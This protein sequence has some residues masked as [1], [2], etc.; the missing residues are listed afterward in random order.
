M[1]RR[2]GLF[3]LFTAALLLLSLLSGARL[4]Y[5]LFFVFTAYLGAAQ[6]ILRANSRD[7][8]HF[9]DF[10]EAELEVGEV[11]SLDFKFENL[12]WL[13]IMG[14]RV[15][16]E[17]LEGLYHVDFHTERH[18]LGSY[19]RVNTRKELTMDHRGYFTVGRILVHFVDPLGCFEK[20]RRF[21]KGIAL[22][23]YPKTRRLITEGWL[24]TYPSEAGSEGKHT[25]QEGDPGGIRPYVLGE[26]LKR[27]L[28][29]H[30]AKRNE[31]VVAER[32]G[33]RQ[34]SV[35]V[36]LH[37]LPEKPD[38][39]TLVSFAWSLIDELLRRGVT[40]V[41]SLGDQL[42]ET[43]APAV[44]RGA[45]TQYR[46]HVNGL[47]SRWT[48]ERARDQ[49]LTVLITNDRAFMRQRTPYRGLL[50]VTDRVEET[51]WPE[52]HTL[53]TVRGDRYFKLDQFSD[54]LARAAL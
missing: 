41:L 40:P 38:S 11:F 25:R 29:K 20:Q 4:F 27:V 5:Y 16:F 47:V 33:N 21:D 28:W 26:P 9:F 39:E 50:V 32:V 1:T 3:L 35:L 12:G 19:A 22:T 30:L 44:Y 43:Q 18:D 7:F 6:W 37:G 54:D 31:M 51:L 10:D 46:F 15:Q 52:V 2:G 45:L 17:A 34:V 53:S 48:L 13:P 14:F 36:A 49:L 8:Y 23:V 42:I 24:M